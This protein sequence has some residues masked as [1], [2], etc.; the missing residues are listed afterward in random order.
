MFKDTVLS[1]LKEHSLYIS[2][3]IQIAQSAVYKAMPNPGVGAVIVHNGK[4]IAEGATSPYGGK[5]AEV[6]AIDKVKDKEL[7][8]QSTLYVTLEP[9]SHH[10]KTPPCAD[11]I[12]K[13]QIPRVVIGTIDPFASVHGK[14]IQKLKQAG[15]EVTVGVL[16]KECQDSNIRFFTFLNKRRPYIILK[17]AQTYNGYIAP[18][19]K[20]HQSPVWISNTYSKQLV[21]KYRSQEVAFLVGTN[22]VLEDNPSLTTRDWYGDN[23]IRIYIDRKGV[24][25]SSFAINDNNS[26]TICFTENQNLKSHDSLSVYHLNFQDNLAQQICEVLY[27]EKIM[28]LVI[29]GGSKTLQSFIDLNLWDQARIFTSQSYL[30]NG[31]IAPKINNFSNHQRRHILEDTLDILTR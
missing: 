20:D 14:G 4:I 12:V 5:H 18:L 15:I 19:E 25:D 9:C 1:I 13:M 23:P 17:W 24:I 27:K 7:L 26:R 6:N 2:R 21:H 31:H 22:T 30:E 28:S 3:A 29:E 8:K 16:E 10:G 11:L